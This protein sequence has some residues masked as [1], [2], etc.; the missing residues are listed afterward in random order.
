MFLF[1]I[2][3]TMT[4]NQIR[5]KLEQLKG[6]KIQVERSFQEVKK[7]I[8]NKTRS[9][10]RHEKA[11]EIIRDVGLKTQQQLQFYISDITTLALNAV[12]DDPYELKVSFVQR[13]NK[14]ECD[15]SFVR[16]ELE[17]DPIEAS[18]VGAIDVA[19]FALR[20]ASWSM[21]RPRSRNVI[22]LDEPFRYLSENYQE[23]ASL[24]VKELSKKLGLQFIIVTHEQVL[25]E[26][27]DRVFEVS[28]KKRI[29]NVKQL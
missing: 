26:H 14:T 2:V 12:F 13:R 6:Q 16:G 1:L 17:I 15:L 28:I 11:R 25:A 4:I 21:M 20:I 27:A 29:S 18:G 10:H 24:M 23:Q 9:L 7:E 5:N 19:S 3:K 8:V 22:I